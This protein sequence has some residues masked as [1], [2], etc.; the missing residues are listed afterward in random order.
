MSSHEKEHFAQLL[1]TVLGKLTPQS[2]KPQLKPISFQELEDSP[3]KGHDDCMHPSAD[4]FPQRKPG[5][6]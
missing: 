1:Q 6:V 3:T 5:N 2:R 4:H